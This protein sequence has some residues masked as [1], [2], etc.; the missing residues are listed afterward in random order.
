MDSSRQHVTDELVEADTLVF[1][2]LHQFLV[3][4]GRHSQEQPSTALRMTR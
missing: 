3:Q 4:A 1:S 2:R